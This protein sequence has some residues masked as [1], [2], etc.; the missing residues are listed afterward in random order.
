MV[1]GR[2]IRLVKVR[3][4]STDIREIQRFP[5]NH[6]RHVV[7]EPMMVFDS[8]YVVGDGAQKKRVVVKD[9]LGRTTNTLVLLNGNK[10]FKVLAVH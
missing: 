2:K 5:F 4:T 8:D 10:Q 6:V 7:H 1:F 9:A 3:E